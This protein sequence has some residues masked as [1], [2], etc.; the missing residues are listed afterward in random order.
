MIIIPLIT[1]KKTILERRGEEER[2]GGRAEGRRSE[3]YNKQPSRL[4]VSSLYNGVLFWS[5]DTSPG[6][7]VTQC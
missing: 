1:I 3:G 2:R 4:E 7:S 6:E 5:S